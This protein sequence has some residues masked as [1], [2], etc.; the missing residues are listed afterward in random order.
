MEALPEA[1][2]DPLACLGERGHVVALEVACGEEYRVLW[3]SADG[4][5]I[6]HGEG[7]G[8]IQGLGDV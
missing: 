6:S 1:M 3:S 8:Q 2:A 4:T 7:S 5:V